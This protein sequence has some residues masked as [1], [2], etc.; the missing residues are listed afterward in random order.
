MTNALKV[1]AKQV[2]PLFYWIIMKQS[3]RVS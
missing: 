2:V 1:A 3:S